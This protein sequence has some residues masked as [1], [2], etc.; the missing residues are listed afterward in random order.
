MS[1]VSYFVVLLLDLC[2]MIV[3]EV[4]ERSIMPIL[5]EG[6][7]SLREI[8]APHVGFRLGMVRSRDSLCCAPDQVS[9]SQSEPGAPD[10]VLHVKQL[11]KVV[12]LWVARD[13]VFLQ[14]SMNRHQS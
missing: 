14:G 6:W 1:V 3:I 13:S 9:P 8:E 11:C 2:V 10:R 7:S 4:N 5:R 12:L